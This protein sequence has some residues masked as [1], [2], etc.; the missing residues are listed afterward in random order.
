M[1][2]S[3]T[4]TSSAICDLLDEMARAD[5]NPLRGHHP[6]PHH[7][8][9]DGPPVR[10]HHGG[11]RRV[12]SSSRSICRAPSAYSKRRKAFGRV[13]VQPQNPD[14]NPVRQPQIARFGNDFRYLTDCYAALTGGPPLICCAR[15]SG[16]G[17]KTFSRN[18]FDGRTP[19]RIQRGGAMKA[20][21]GPAAP[22][23]PIF[24]ATEVARCTA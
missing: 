22:T 15:L 24:S 8:G 17:Q 3:T 6:Q 16:P 5:R 19:W 11:A 21:R 12:A 13:T 18:C 14:R 9:A 4:P 20:V 7:H 1:R 10:R 23:M 2:R